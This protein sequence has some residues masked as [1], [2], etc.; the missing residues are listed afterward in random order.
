MNPDRLTNRI[1]I[2]DYN[3]C[4]NSCKE[5]KTDFE[6]IRCQEMFTNKLACNL[7]TVKNKCKDMQNVEWKHLLSNKPK[8]RTYVKFKEN[9]C[10]EDYVKQCTSRRKRSLMAQF[11]IGILPLHIETGRLRDKRIN[12]RVCLLCTSGEVENE[13]HFLCVCTTYSNYKPNLY[14]IVNNDNF[15]NMSN[16]EKFVFLLK[17]KWKYVCIY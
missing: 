12:E 8:L 4:K 14:S 10:T 6:L 3:L 9:I 11:R 17:F 7:T 13:L 5:V 2:W 16:D 1:C 15:L